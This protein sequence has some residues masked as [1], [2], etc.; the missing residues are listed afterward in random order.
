M[1][2]TKVQNKRSERSNE[3]DKGSGGITGPARIGRVRFSQTGKSI[4]YKG[5]MF[6]SLKGRGFKANSLT[7]RPAINT[8]FPA[9]KRWL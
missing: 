3:E 2:A 5:K 9:A 4:Y 8:G 7:L 1:P 6:Q